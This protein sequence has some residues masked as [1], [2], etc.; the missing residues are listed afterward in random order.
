MELETTRER[1]GQNPKTHRHDAGYPDFLDD[2]LGVIA[3]GDPVFT[4][5][6]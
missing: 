1:S 2:H 4:A 5:A 6:A 3:H